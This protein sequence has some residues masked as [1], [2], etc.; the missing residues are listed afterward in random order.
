M[1]SKRVK[2]HALRVVKKFGAYWGLNLDG[3]GS[4]SL[5]I[6]DGKGGHRL[7]NR[8]IHAGIPGAERVNANHL[9]LFAKPLQ[10]GL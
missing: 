10:K 6:S 7:L 1:N 9:G 8:P 3:G 4:T 5:V 2:M